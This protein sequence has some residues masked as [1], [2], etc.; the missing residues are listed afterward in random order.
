MSVNGQDFRD[1][2]KDALDIL[3]TKEWPSS[4]IGALQGIL[5][6]L[7]HTQTQAYLYRQ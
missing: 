1:I 6:N 2:S 7:V 5:E 3:V 4:L